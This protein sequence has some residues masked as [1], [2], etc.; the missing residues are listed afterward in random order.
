MTVK[1]CKAT[2]AVAVALLA[3]A[4]GGGD[5]TFPADTLV[6]VGQRCLTRSDVAALVRSGLSP[7]DSASAAKAYIRSWIDGELVASVASSE[8]DMEEIDRLTAEYRNELIKAQYRRAMAAKASTG[9]F[10]ED[11]IR[12]YYDSHIR[13]FVLERPML[14]GIYIKVPETAKELPTLRR[15]Y[16]SNKPDDIDR[17][18]K[19]ALN[20]A[21][22]Y[23][24]FRDKW[25]DR[26]Q[27]ENRIPVDFSGPEGT[28]LAAKKPLEI[29]AGGFVYLLSVSDYL[30]AGADMPYEAAHPMVRER[31]LAARRLAYDAELRNELFSRA[32]DDGT[33]RFFGANPLK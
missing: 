12:A 31:L 14:K 9:V 33:I 32:L 21:I 30:P 2:V 18:E 8:V 28:A 22:H 11:S 4:C 25:I 3:A 24:Y 20:S 16:K 23:D 29:K 26:E 10:S 7:A 5:S 6:A 27:I 15:L 17:L 1:T 13:D 19:V